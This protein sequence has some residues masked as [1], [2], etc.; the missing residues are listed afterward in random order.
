VG[1]FFSGRARLEYDGKALAQRADIVL[2]LV[3]IVYE[4]LFDEN[5]N[6]SR[7]WKASIIGAG[8]VNRVGRLVPTAGSGSLLFP[9]LS[10][11][12]PS[13]VAVDT[14]SRRRQINAFI[15]EHDTPELAVVRRY[16]YWN[17]LIESC[18]TAIKSVDEWVAQLAARINTRTAASAVR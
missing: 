3:Q 9:L 18:A 2:R 11:N 7:S 4:C 13:V 16:P 10:G 6:F 12:R 1:F 15:A 17:R 5:G 8:A 14:A